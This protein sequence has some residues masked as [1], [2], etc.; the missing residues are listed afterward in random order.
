MG[1]V[2]L[3]IEL[4]LMIEELFPTQANVFALMRCHSSTHAIFQNRLYKRAKGDEILEN[5]LWACEMG[6][7]GLGSANNVEQQRVLSYKYQAPNFDHLNML[8]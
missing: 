7:E 1:L 3:P 4:I 2:D 8:S 6:N 5:L